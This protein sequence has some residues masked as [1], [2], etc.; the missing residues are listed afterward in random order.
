M[1]GQKTVLFIDDEI[2]LQ[3]LVKITLRS[4]GYNVE[5]ASNGIEGLEKLKTIK[6]DLNYFI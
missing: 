4:R 6:P 1:S 5:I 3:E 2:D